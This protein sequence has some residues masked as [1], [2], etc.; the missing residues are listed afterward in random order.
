MEVEFIDVPDET[1][2]PEPKAGRPRKYA[3][4]AERRE[5]KRIQ[6]RERKKRARTKAKGRAEAGRQ[7][8]SDELDELRKAYA[9]APEARPDAEADPVPAPGPEP[10]PAPPMGHILLAITDTVAPFVIGKAM[11]RDTSR[12]ALT[13]GEKEK[14]GPLADAA[15]EKLLAKT[16]PVRL[17]VLTVGSLYM[18]KAQALPKLPP[19]RTNKAGA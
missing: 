12:L 1:P 18:A 7:D 14:L 17:F 4:E 15:A 8:A 5:A 6:D 9:D 3:T 16:D 2:A 13:A 11:R 19:K 10:E